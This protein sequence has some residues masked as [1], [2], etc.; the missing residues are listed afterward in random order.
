MLKTTE[1]KKEVKA[2]MVTR[3]FPETTQQ[4]NE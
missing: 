4:G 3:L 1:A 2:M